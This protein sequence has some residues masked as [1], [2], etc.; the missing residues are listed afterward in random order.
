[1]LSIRELMTGRY[2]RDLFLT[3]I[4]VGFGAIAGVVLGIPLVG[5]LLTPL[6]EPEPRVWRN[7]ARIAPSGDVIVPGFGNLAVGE[8][9]EV[10]YQDPN[11]LSWSGSTTKAGAYL[12]R[13]SQTQF[14]VFSMYCTHLGCPLHWLPPPGDLFLCP[15]HGSAFYA[16]GSVA[17]GPA[18]LPMVRLP[19][20]VHRGQVQIKTSPIPVA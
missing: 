1:M 18:Q 10:R 17:V 12:R 2:A 7:V 15:C 19:V 5:Y 6:F 11:G 3:G 8:T 20:R 14:I 16:D 13:E 9:T 4:V